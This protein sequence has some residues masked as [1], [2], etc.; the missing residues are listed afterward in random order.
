MQAARWFVVLALL[1][2]C[3]RAS[4]EG[5]AKQWAASPPG[6]DIAIPASLS[7]AVTIDG[8]P[9]PAITG[10][11]LRG[12]HPDFADDERKAWR[13]STLLP[14]A[15]RAGSVVEAS[16][17]GGIS[18][19]LSQPTAD[20]LEPVL[21]LT[22]RGEIIVAALDPKDPFPRYHG[23]GGR[24]RRAGDPTP[25]VSAVARIAVSHVAPAP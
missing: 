23:Q 8:A 10:D 17:S 7:I 3:S 20:G 2:G 16:S 6:K 15:G 1:G 24:L 14:E 21:F 18:V 11:R 5:E 22:R 19:K 13:V 4:D 25:R 12:I 9:R